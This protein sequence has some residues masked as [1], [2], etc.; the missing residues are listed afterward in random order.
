MNE[1]TDRELIRI[2]LRLLDVIKS[3]FVEEPDAERLS[4]WR[5]FIAALSDEPVNPMMDSAVSELLGLLSETKLDEIRDEYYE[6]FTNPF[7]GDTV[8][9]NLSHY[10]DGHSFGQSLVD[11]R[12]FMMDVGL[13]RKKDVDETEDSLVF[14]LDVL[15]ALIEEEKEN[16]EE[17]RIRQ[18][19]LIHEYL[20]PLTDH[21]HT[22]LQENDRARFYEVCAG[23]LAG[24][25]DLE[26][27]MAVPFVNQ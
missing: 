18:T 21:F 10:I 26:K 2:R 11:F 8:K 23:F 24:Y 4:R 9:T 19:E 7:S 17:V 5:G 3:F 22:A 15:A 6:L 16:P 20:N 1:L 12:G 13:A 14:M 25:V 27:G